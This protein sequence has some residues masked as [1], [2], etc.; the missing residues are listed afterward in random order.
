M[1]NE[2]DI[3]RDVSARLELGNLASTGCDTGYV[4]RWTNELGLFNLWQEC[5]P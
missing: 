4:E 5:N 3:V 2:L 1:Q